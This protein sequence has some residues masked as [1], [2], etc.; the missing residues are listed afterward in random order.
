MLKVSLAVHT[1]F[2]VFFVFFEEGGGG[3]YSCLLG[4]VVDLLAL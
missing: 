1:S 3:D 2:A 4:C